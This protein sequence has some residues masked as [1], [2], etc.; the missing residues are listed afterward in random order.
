VSG[1]FHSPDMAQAQAA[2]EAYL[3]QVTLAA[4]KIPVYA[5]HT[6]RP[7]ARPYAPILASQA[8]HP[9]RWQE[10]LENMAAEGVTTFIEVGPG[11]TLSGFVRKTLPNAVVLN[12]EDAESLTR[13]IDALNGE[14]PC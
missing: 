3:D 10:T 9:V 8:A 2:L 12:V 14:K 7:Y 5:N 4:P 11:K 6:A 13:T 1:A